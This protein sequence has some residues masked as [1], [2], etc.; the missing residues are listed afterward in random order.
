MAIASS[1]VGFCSPSASFGLDFIH[2]AI[3]S[4]TANDYVNLILPMRVQLLRSTPFS[5][6]AYKNSITEQVIMLFGSCACF[7][8][9]LAC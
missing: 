6:I 1:Y 5:K 3:F 7:T 2:R 8:G 4:L 9:L